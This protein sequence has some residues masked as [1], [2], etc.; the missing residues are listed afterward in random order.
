MTLLLKDNN[1]N[2]SF[3]PPQS[4][5]FSIN[6]QYFFG[7]LIAATTIF[8]VA[9]S[10]ENAPS[11]EKKQGKESSI[12]IDDFTSANVE[13]A[14][15]PENPYDYF[16]KAHFDGVVYV[17]KDLN[18]SVTAPVSTIYQSAVKFEQTLNTSSFNT[19][20]SSS[21]HQPTEEELM[22]AYQFAKQNFSFKTPEGASPELKAELKKLS[23][24][25]RQLDMEEN[26]CNYQKIK[27]GIVTYETELLKS[28]TLNGDEKPI[29][30]KMTA[31]ARYSALQWEQPLTKLMAQKETS[32]IAKSVKSTKGKRWYHWLMIAAADAGGAV[33]GY[34]SDEGIVSSAVSA[35]K[36]TY[37]MIT[38]DL[39]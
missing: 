13:D 23:E 28:S 1:I 32:S 2:L 20:R 14:A 12:T 5:M 36:A 22:S 37:D 18:G 3:Y 11:N 30:L 34:F 16:G 29:L 10:K 27:Q 17:V 9:C 15:N 35:S 8:G 4:L 31:I 19:R 6:K 24:V 33:V 39:K 7:V 38:E 25:F 21:A 26:D